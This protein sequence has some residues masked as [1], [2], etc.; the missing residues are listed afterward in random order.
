MQII[1]KKLVE[2]LYPPLNH[3][4]VLWVDKDESSGDWKSIK[5]YHEGKGWE[6]LLSNSEES[7]INNEY[8]YYTYLHEVDKLIN[9]N[10]IKDNDS[11]PI[12]GISK[13]L[14]TKLAIATIKYYIDPPDDCLFSVS[15][16]TYFGG[17]SIKKDPFTKESFK[18]LLAFN[19]LDPSI[20]DLSMRSDSLSSSGNSQK[21]LPVMFVGVGIS[22]IQVVKYLEEVFYS[23]KETLKVKNYCANYVYP[24]EY[25]LWTQSK[26]EPAENTDIIAIL[27]APTSLDEKHAYFTAIRPSESFMELF[28]INEYDLNIVKNSGYYEN[29]K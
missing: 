12:I 19:N 6:D 21:G 18:E 23:K 24:G 14:I 8:R 1:N 28:D 4:G 5:E 10:Y 2:S 25:G 3:N 17:F 22:S 15:G 26:D 29:Y 13:E 9:E 11:D 27:I 7:I 20:A 16:S